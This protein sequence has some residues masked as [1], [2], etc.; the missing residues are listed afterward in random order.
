MKTI[1][2]DL[3]IIREMSPL[4]LDDMRLLLNYKSWSGLSR[5]ERGKQAPSLE[6]IICYHLMFGVPMDSLLKYEIQRL[7]RKLRNMILKRLETLKTKELEVSTQDR[8]KF[9]NTKYDDFGN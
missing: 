1:N 7:K 8:I 5:V 4:I 3:G 6:V 2:H 9:L